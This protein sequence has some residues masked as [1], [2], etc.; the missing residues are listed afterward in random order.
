LFNIDGLVRF[1]KEMRGGI[2]FDRCE[3]T[4]ND[5]KEARVFYLANNQVEIFYVDNSII[6]SGQKMTNE[7]FMKI[8]R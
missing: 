6:T 1:S 2:I 4:G 8:I 5:G 7:K 3:F